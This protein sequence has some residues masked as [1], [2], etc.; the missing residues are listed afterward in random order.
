MREFWNSVKSFFDATGNYIKSM[1][2][3]ALE[4]LSLRT[5][6]P[7]EVERMEKQSFAGVGNKPQRFQ[8]LRGPFG[9]RVLNR[10]LE[11]GRSG[12]HRPEW[13]HGKS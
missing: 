3:R 1:W 12:S 7:E 9:W 8:F 6:P 13:R 11:R 5:V 2:I 4:I 10:R